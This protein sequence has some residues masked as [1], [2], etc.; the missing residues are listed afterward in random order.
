MLPYPP[1]Y[2]DDDEE[3]VSSGGKGSEG[4]EKPDKDEGGYQ[5]Q[6][7]TLIVWTDRDANVDMALSFATAAGCSDTWEFIQAARKLSCEFPVVFLTRPR[8]IELS[9]LTG[10]FADEHPPTSPSPTPSLSSPQPF[11]AYHVAPHVVKIPEPSLGNIADVEASIRV[12]VRTAVG[13]ERTAMLIVQNQIVQKLIHVQEEAEDLESLEDLHAL[14]RVMQ[15]IRE[16]P[17][18]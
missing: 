6:Q 10:T 7:D 12:M 16:F 11:P 14:C 17:L 4:A 3:D 9:I 1:G 15:T 2:F 18:G 13:R 8:P 5:K